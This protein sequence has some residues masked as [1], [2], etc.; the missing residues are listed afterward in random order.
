MAQRT[1]TNRFADQLIKINNYMRLIA[2]DNRMLP[3][4]SSSKDP[5]AAQAN[6]AAPSA[7]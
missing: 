1:Y 7:S 3:V 6:A 4:R 2:G 5:A